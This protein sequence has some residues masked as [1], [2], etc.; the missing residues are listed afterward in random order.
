MTKLDPYIHV[1]PLYEEHAHSTYPLEL[2]A[3]N[4]RR[5]QDSP[6][7]RWLPYG[8]YHQTGGGEVLFNRDGC[9]L[10]RR[11]RHDAP[12]RE[13]GHTEVVDYYARSW[14]FT[15]GF[16]VGVA[17]TGH[18]YACTN[19]A[20][21]VLRDW[22]VPAPKGV[23]KPAYLYRAY[24]EASVLLYVGEAYN[25]LVRASGHLDGSHWWDRVRNLTVTPYPSKEAARAAEVI[26]IR[27]EKPLYNV[28]HNQ[29]RGMI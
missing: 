1:P 10:W 9:P 6:E 12:A 28:A 19:Y 13:I 21:S 4:W 24:D 22:G 2:A 25:T 23:M 15:A 11:A 3:M 7:R 17:Y 20:L 8:I 27:E 29:R 5:S 26:A 14:I 18:R 16:I